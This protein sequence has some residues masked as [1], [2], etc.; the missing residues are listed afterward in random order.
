MDYE[1]DNTRAQS[2]AKEDHNSIL[3]YFNMYNLR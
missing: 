2:L 1:E 3:F